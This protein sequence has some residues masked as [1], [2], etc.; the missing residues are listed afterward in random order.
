MR[1]VFGV[2]AAFGAAIG[3][4][5]VALPAFAAERGSAEDGGLLLA[6]LSAG[7]LAGG[8]VYGVRR[9]P[10]PPPARLAVLLLALGTGC[11]LLSLPDAA[12]VLVPLLVAT[13]VLI[14]PIAVLGSTLLDTAAPPGT[15]TEAFAVMVMGIVAGNAAGNALGG[16]VVESA[17]YEAAALA[18]GALAALGAVAAAA[19]R[20][21]LAR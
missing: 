4:L 18:A 14:A 21:T 15:V 9:W 10:G 7:S 1:V 17:S 13:G 2:M 16:A 19:G 20:R 3:V 12:A 5:Q 6:A 8:I 11:A